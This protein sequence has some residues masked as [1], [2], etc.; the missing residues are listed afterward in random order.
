MCGSFWAKNDKISKILQESTRTKAESGGG[1]IE[2]ETGK[3]NTDEE[4]L[5]GCIARCSADGRDSAAK[6]ASESFRRGAADRH[7]EC[8]PR[9]R[10]IRRWL[11]LG[12]RRQDS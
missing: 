5:R 8:C 4:D 1:F 7:Q 11:R 6:E 12:S 3:E 2:A 9:A 10:R